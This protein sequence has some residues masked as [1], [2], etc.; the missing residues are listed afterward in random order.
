MELQEEDDGGII[1]DMLC[2]WRYVLDDVF[3]KVKAVSCLGAT[4]IDKRVDEQGKPI[5]VR[6]MMQL[7][8]HSN[9]KTV[10]S[11]ILIRPG[12]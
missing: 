7:M 3:G 9:W 10:L 12:Q 2:H 11:H 8:L 4:H 1:V 5:N 6:L